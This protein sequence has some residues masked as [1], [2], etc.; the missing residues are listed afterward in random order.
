MHIYLCLCELVVH[1][2]HTW[3]RFIQLIV[4][5]FYLVFNS[6]LRQFQLLVS[7]AV[8][9]ILLEIQ[10]FREFELHSWVHFVGYI[11]LAVCALLE[12]FSCQE[13]RLETMEWAVCYNVAILCLTVS[14]QSSCLIWQVLAVNKEPSMDTAISIWQQ[15]KLR[16]QVP[17]FCCV[18]HLDPRL[19][20]KSGW[21]SNCSRGSGLAETFT[22][23]QLEPI[24][25][26]DGHKSWRVGCW[27]ISR[28]CC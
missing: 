6:H 14:N 18:H 15:R 28:F 21:H 10:S 3:L 2:L 12:L 13:C 20:K 27:S 1:S 22:C 5:F 26:M 19:L 23:I 9:L 24:G 25:A 4:T 16:D 7:M 17:T 8:L 11:Y